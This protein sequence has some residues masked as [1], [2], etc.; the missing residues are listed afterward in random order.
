ME[1]ANSCAC[2]N[3]LLVRV[4]VSRRVM[5]FLDSFNASDGIESASATF[6]ELGSFFSSSPAI[7]SSSSGCPGKAC[8]IYKKRDE[9]EW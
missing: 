7:A 4:C 5:P 1:K 2:E 3:S 8:K 9:K 6:I